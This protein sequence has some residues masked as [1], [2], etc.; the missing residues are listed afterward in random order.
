[1]KQTASRRDAQRVRLSQL[2]AFN[3]TG[4]RLFTVAA[5]KPQTMSIDL[6]MQMRSFIVGHHSMK[7]I[8]QHQLWQ[9]RPVGG[10][11]EQPSF[12]LELTARMFGDR[13]R[14]VI[15]NPEVD[16]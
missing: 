1:M 13:L 9:R 6:T 10:H 7:R 15:H 16:T 2:N 4:R 3:A 11:V 5:T 14:A 12:G 8:S